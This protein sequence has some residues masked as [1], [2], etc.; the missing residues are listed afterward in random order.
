MSSRKT[1]NMPVSVIKLYEFILFSL[2]ATILSSIDCNCFD[3]FFVAFSSDTLASNSCLLGALA[4]FMYS[5]AYAYTCVYNQLKDL[6][7]QG[8]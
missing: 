1:L 6:F 4:T 8:L 3:I 7:L 5:H 2:Q